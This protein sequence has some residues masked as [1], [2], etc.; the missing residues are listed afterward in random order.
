VTRLADAETGS[1]SK[2][3]IWSAASKSA[4]QSSIDWLNLASIARI[5]LFMVWRL[6]PSSAAVEDTLRP[7]A[8]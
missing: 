6:T 5:R 1:L 2:C 4:A 3:S 7:T 8:K